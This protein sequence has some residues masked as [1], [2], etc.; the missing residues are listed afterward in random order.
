MSWAGIVQGRVKPLPIIPDLQIVKDGEAR[1]ST[2]GEWRRRALGLERTPQALHHSIVEA[3]AAAAH[4]DGN[5]VLGKQSP[6]IVAGVLAALV[7]VMKQIAA[8]L[9]LS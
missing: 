7:R 9:T 5:A 3:V 2:G 1:G 4:A 6:V 8:W